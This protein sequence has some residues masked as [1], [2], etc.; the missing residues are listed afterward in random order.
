MNKQYRHQL[1]V[2]LLLLCGLLLPVVVQPRAISAQSDESEP[3]PIVTWYDLYRDSPAFPGCLHCRQ[4]L[5]SERLLDRD[6]LHRIQK[7][8][9]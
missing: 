9:E 1:I 6:H 7:T 4:P 3:N 2:R 5:L 8:T